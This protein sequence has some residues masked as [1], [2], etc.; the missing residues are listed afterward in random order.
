MT[1]GKYWDDTSFG[2]IIAGI[3]C[4][5][6]LCLRVIIDEV[7][8]NIG[9]MGRNNFLLKQIIRGGANTRNNTLR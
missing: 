3:R 8:E 6:F 1:G 4:P 9:R 5:F 7:S 2:G